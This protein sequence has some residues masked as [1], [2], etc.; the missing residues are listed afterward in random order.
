MWDFIYQNIIKKLPDADLN[1]EIESF[2]ICFK[3]NAKTIEYSNVK[4]EGENLDGDGNEEVGNV[5][6]Q[7]NRQSIISKN[8]TIARSI[9]KIDKEEQQELDDLK[10]D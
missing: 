8:N 4:N 2:K 7:M 3:K 9:A 5:H 1:A 10:K 6:R